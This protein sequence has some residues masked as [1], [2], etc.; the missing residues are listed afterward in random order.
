MSTEEKIKKNNIEK[1]ITKDDFREKEAY[2]KFP[3]AFSIVKMLYIKCYLFNKSS[4]KL[5]S[6]NLLLDSG[7]QKSILYLNIIKKFNL[8][9]IVDNRYKSDIFGIGSSKEGNGRIHI[10]ELF[11]TPNNFKKIDKAEI[12]CSFTVVDDVCLGFQ[13]SM[14]D[15]DGIFGLDMLM[16]YNIKVDYGNKKLF[17]NDY[18]FSLFYL[19]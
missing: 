8:E 14:G 16:R 6:V 5:E 18:E 7:A 12:I 11:L 19:D 15:I 9:N 3:D 13:E 10:L 1:L 4:N 2:E 17:I